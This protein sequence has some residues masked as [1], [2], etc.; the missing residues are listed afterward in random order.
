MC[1]ALP[2]LTTWDTPTFVEGKRVGLIV[3][4]MLGLP[5]DLHTHA[6]KGLGQLASVVLDR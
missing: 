3:D 2:I 1:G 4:F 6:M 5:T